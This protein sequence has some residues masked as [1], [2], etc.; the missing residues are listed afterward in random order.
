[1][2][3]NPYMI[4]KQFEVTGTFTFLID[5]MVNSTMKFPQSY[6]EIAEESSQEETERIMRGFRYV[7]EEFGMSGESNFNFEIKETDLTK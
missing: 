3:D 4:P 1:M 7:L 2:S 6:Q 5:M